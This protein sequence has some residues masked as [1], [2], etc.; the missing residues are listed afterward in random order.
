MH[1]LKQHNENTFE[2]IKRIN[3]Y[4][5][6]YWHARELGLILEYTSWQ[7]YSNV[8]QCAIQACESSGNIAFDYFA[9]VS[10]MIKTGKGAQREVQVFAV[11]L[12]LLSIQELGGA[13]P[14]DLPTP[15]KSIQQIEQEKRN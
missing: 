10:K 6:E 1:E 12:R 2:D 9:E 13:M 5:Q 4:E 8:I 11:T 14:E 3:E 7:N 15:E